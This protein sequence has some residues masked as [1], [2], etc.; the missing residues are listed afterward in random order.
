MSAAT[1]DSDPKSYWNLR[2][3]VA[4]VVAIVLHVFCFYIFQV[5]DPKVSRE[6]PETSHVTYLSPDDPSA[7][8]VLR[9][10]D[11]YYAAF[12]GALRPDSILRAPLRLASLEERPVRHQL[13]LMP[14]PYVGQSES[15][16]GVLPPLP[17]TGAAPIPGLTYSPSVRHRA[18]DRELDWDDDPGTD[19]SAWRVA[20]DPVGK[21]LH[22]FPA[23]GQVPSEQDLKI[24]EAVSRLR[25]S[26]APSLTS[27]E[28]GTVTFKPETSAAP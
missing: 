3:L 7:A 27:L 5:Q 17:N 4:A 2:L 11:D 10:L 14:S 8:A 26:A 9:R 22:V 6:L 18:L 13:D 20:I 23:D 16:P 19:L 1:A 15:F 24:G 28:W 25:F 12:D 21:V